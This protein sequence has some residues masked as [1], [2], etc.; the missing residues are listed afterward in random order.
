M[1]RSVTPLD[2][3]PH[4][5]ELARQLTLYEHDLFKRVRALDLVHKVKSGEA[6]TVASVS[7]MIRHFNAMTSFVA[8]CVLQ[9]TDRER[10]VA[11]VQKMIALGHRCYTLGNLNGAMEVVAGLG[12]TPVRRLTETWAGVDPAARKAFTGLERL[13]SAERNFHRYRALLRKLRPPMVPY[14]GLYLRD[15]TMTLHSNQD[16]LRCGMLNTG[17]LRD[18]SVLLEDMEA[19]Q[20]GSYP[21]IVL[22][23]VRAML[24][25]LAPVDEDVLFERSYAVQPPSHLRK[26]SSTSFFG[27]RL[28]G[29]SDSNSSNSLRGR[30]A[31]RH[32]TLST[33]VK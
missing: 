1:Q 21:L 13:M 5:L 22:P 11:L 25:G 23:N 14:F 24:Q 20:Q 15:L 10:R 12:L 17:K 33:N 27:F 3:T 32:R 26:A 18:L 19:R 16:T 4:P 28:T 9:E 8:A 7:A 31:S 30:R 2:C 6:A 29:D